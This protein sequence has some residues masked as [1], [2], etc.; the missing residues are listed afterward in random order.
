M[1]TQNETLEEKIIQETTEQNKENIRINDQETA[2]T[3]KD[4]NDALDPNKTKPT[5]S[6]QDKYKN[7]LEVTQN[8]KEEI[9]KIYALV[10]STTSID[11]NKITSKKDIK[12][13]YSN[14]ELLKKEIKTLEERIRGKETY[15]MPEAYDESILKY[16]NR[17]DPKKKG[18]YFREQEINDVLILLKNKE[19]DYKYAIEDTATKIDN[20]TKQITD[21]Q[22]LNRTQ[23]RELK[24]ERINLNRQIKLYEQRQTELNYEIDKY[25]AKAKTIKHEI[26]T[27]ENILNKG[28]NTLYFTEQALEIIS[29]NLEYQSSPITTTINTIDKINTHSGKMKQYLDVHGNEHQN[30]LERIYKESDKLITNQEGEEY[31][32]TYNQKNKTI[33]S[34]DS[35]VLKAKR[36]NFFE[37]LGY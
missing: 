26:Q 32:D 2:N 4:I 36:N 22:E 34:Q 28:R 33:R 13:A 7:Y 5:N 10:K 3:I 16:I 9:K 21:S 11:L 1:N 18:L 30:S 23:L 37:E 35:A 17:I 25:V 29:T 14:L 27:I 19:S 31:F 24:T 6:E 15:K 12:K 8:Q 20:I